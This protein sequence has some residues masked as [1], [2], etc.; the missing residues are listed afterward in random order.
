MEFLQKIDW[1]KLQFEYGLFGKRLLPWEKLNLPFGG[2]YCVVGSH[3]TS[4]SHINEPAGEEELFIAISGRAKVWLGNGS[5]EM[6]KGDVLFIPAGIS[7]YIENDNREDFHLYA[8]WWNTGTV[9]SYL[10]TTPNE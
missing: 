2:A 5:Y 9:N 6:E 1:D 4:T 8:L 7:H 10:N 3:T